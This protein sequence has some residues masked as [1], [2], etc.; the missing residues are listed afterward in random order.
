MLAEGLTQTPTRRI[1]LRAS[2]LPRQL[3][4]RAYGDG[5]LWV[6]AGLST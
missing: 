5:P 2:L 1:P 6:R 3:T 4:S